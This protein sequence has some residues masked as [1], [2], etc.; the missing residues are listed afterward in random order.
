MTRAT[1]AALFGLLFAATGACAQTL[2]FNRGTLPIEFEVPRG[3]KFHAGHEIVV[4]GNVSGSG[5]AEVVL[6]VDDGASKDWGS[7]FNREQNLTSGFFRMRVPLSELKTR[8]G[9]PLDLTDLRRVV[10]GRFAGNATVS[11]TR[12]AIT[13][14]LPSSFP[15]PT[16]LPTGRTTI[17]YEPR[18]PVVFGEHD[19]ITIEGVVDGTAPSGLLIRLDDTQSVS[20]PTRV[21]IERQVAPGPFRFRVQPKGLKTPSGRALDYGAVTRIV[22]AVYDGAGPVRITRFH[23]AEA[24]RVPDG[25]KAYAIAGPNAPILPGLERIAPGDPRLGGGTLLPVTRIA[26]DPAVAS[27]MRNL[28]F[29]RL[30]WPGGRARVSLFTEDPGEWELLPNPLRRTIR[31]N[32]AIALSRSMTPEQWIAERYLRQA[33]AEHGPQDDAWTA[34]GRHRGDVVSIEVDTTNIGIIIELTGDDA[35][36]KFLSTV[37]V[38]PAGQKAALEFVQ[39]Q[40]AEW[41]RSNF[42]VGKRPDPT[43]PP[44]VRAVLGSGTL[45]VL[46]ATAAAGSGVWLTL[47]VT[48]PARIETPRVRLEPPAMEGKALGARLWAGQR[49]LERDGLLVLRDNR[50]LSDVAGL[51]IGPDAPRSYEIWIAVPGDAARGTY[52]GAVEFAATGTGERVAIEVDVLGARLPPVAKPAGF[53]HFATPHYDWFKPLAARVRQQT[54]CDLETLAFFDAAAGTAPSGAP[55]KLGQLGAFLED[56]RIAQRGGVAPGWLLYGVG[57]DEAQSVEN[58]AKAIGAAGALMITS[59]LGE[60]LWSAADEPSNPDQ[61]VD[62]RGWVAALRQ[63]APLVKLAG[64]LNSKGDEAMAPLFD[65]AVI[66]PGYGL[67]RQRIDSL[68]SRGRRVWL[69]NTD[70]PRL[71][72]GLWLWN[73]P[74]VRYVQW[75]ARSPQADP[76]DP[77]DG[78]EA[79]YQMFYP[80]VAACPALPD[81]DRSVLRLANGVVDQRWLLWLD[82]QK[83]AE[84]ARIKADITRRAGASWAEA[85]KLGPAGLD[86]IRAL[87]TDHARKLDGAGAPPQ[88]GAKP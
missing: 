13:T 83:S 32:G 15:K 48:A 38:E 74:A 5:A 41:Y 16:D 72:A 66:N 7:R 63:H 25:A 45:P 9:R 56:M 14:P 11:V 77:T 49:R 40:R 30:P 67:D 84:A 31:V 42:S 51:P 27:G 18:T 68:V 23:V 6:R 24:E 86:R 33:S 44:G 37:V 50:L 79:D 85:I 39:R 82:G 69:Y 71:A 73:T 57:T 76:F 12:A 29:V 20:Y 64:H 59:G 54:K 52:R 10:F 17:A 47:A 53:Y 81:I 3:T 26:P 21:N 8:E 70:D 34:Y 46:R 4:E 58:R 87:I 35:D 80:T 75:H 36:G 1:I 43:A 62:V 60:P 22:L 28:D 61:N 88:A 19:I 2:E 55:V 65:V 78:R